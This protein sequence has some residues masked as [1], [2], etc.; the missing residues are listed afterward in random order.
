VKVYKVIADRP[1]TAVR[2][3]KKGAEETR[4]YLQKLKSL[5]E[6]IG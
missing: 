6:E 4:K 1:R 2:I 5:L 3:T